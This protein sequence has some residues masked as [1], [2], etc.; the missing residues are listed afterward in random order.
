M[1]TPIVFA[2]HKLR[3]GNGNAVD[4]GTDTLK[5]AIMKSTWTPNVAT[6]T[7]LSDINSNEVSGTN[8][9]AGGTAIAG[10]TFALDGNDPEL[11]Y[12]DTVWSQHASGFANGRHFVLYKDTG[13]A[14]TSPLIHYM[15]NGSDF[16]NVSGD[17]TH[18][19]DPATGTLKY[20]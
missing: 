11:I 5:I 4:Y 10:V 19:V 17:L 14:A 2:N 6:N 12:N 7:F 16:G 13:V 1:P 3:Q 8:Y 9:T 18:D 20:V 15:D